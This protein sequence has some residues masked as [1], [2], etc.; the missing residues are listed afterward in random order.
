MRGKASR[1]LIS[2]MADDGSRRGYDGLLISISHSF[3]L[4]FLLVQKKSAVTIETLLRKGF[5]TTE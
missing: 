3:F 5:W 1:G 2:P 4:R